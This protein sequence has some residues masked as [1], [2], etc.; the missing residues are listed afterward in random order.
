VEKIRVAL[1]M[2]TEHVESIAKK[3]D[4]LLGNIVCCGCTDIGRCRELSGSCAKHMP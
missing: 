2:T 4:V 3:S 1:T